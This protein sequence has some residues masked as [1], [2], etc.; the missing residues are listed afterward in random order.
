MNGNS[1]SEEEKDPKGSR[2]R[3]S[4]LRIFKNLNRMLSHKQFS[5]SKAFKSADRYLA[6]KQITLDTIS[7][8]KERKFLVWLSPRMFAAVVTFIVAVAL[9]TI[10]VS[11]FTQG[12]SK[13]SSTLLPQVQTSPTAKPVVDVWGEYEKLSQTDARNLRKQGN[14][15]NLAILDGGGVTYLKGY[16]VKFNLEKPSPWQVMNQPPNFTNLSVIGTGIKVGADNQ[17]YALNLYQGFV[18][19]KDPNNLYLVDQLGH[20]WTT[21]YS[22]D[23]IVSLDQVHAPIQIAPNPDLNLTY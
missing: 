3:F 13:P 7:T 11:I 9:V 20:I 12:F 6:S 18:R 4:I 16:G 15:L 5:V 10:V 8:E 2:N 1:V 23:V 14:V 19:L 21:L 22:K 17:T